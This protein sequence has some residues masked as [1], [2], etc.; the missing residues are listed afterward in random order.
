MEEL[1]TKKQESSWTKTSKELRAIKARQE[2]MLIFGDCNWAV[3]S[4]QNGVEDN[5]SEVS[6]G[7]RLV[8]ELIATGHYHMLL[9]TNQAEVGVMTIVCPATG[10]SSCLNFDFDFDK[11][12]PT[13]QEGW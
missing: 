6:F 9:N 3:G 10:N 4:S 2:C 1:K 8:R 11:S 13:C 5:K 7:E 12:A